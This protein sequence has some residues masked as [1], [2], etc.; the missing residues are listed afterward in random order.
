MSV[1]LI[2][3]HFCD[4][5]KV[6][7]FAAS[8]LEAEPRPQGG[9]AGCQCRRGVRARDL[10]EVRKRDVIHDLPY[11]EIQIIED[12]VYVKAEFQLRIFSQHWQVR[13]AETL[14]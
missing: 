11:I 10:A 4:G 7:P 9:G 12:V 14:G 13:K 5:E 2:P 6:T 8:L 3:Q 1:G